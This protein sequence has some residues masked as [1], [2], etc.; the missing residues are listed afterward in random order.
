LAK[1]Q[2]ALHAQQEA[3]AADAAD[4]NRDSHLTETRRCGPNAVRRGGCERHADVTTRR[5]RV[6]EWY[7][8]L[9]Q[10][11]TATAN[12]C[13]ITPVSFPGWTAGSGGADRDSITCSN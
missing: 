5:I 13:V 4:Q 9:F 10:R 11:L 12:T 1:A 6:T 8:F 3:G 2:Q 7:E